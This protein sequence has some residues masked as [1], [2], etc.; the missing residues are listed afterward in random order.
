MKEVLF[1]AYIAYCIRNS[2]LKV[3][4]KAIFVSSLKKATQKQK[5]ESKFWTLVLQKK[6]NDIF[7]T[8]QQM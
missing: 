4:P 5:L 8:E 1:E 6:I 7:Y 2:I 3:T